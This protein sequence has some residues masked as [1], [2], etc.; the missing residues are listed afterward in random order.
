MAMQEQAWA[1][2]LRRERAGDAS[3]YAWFLKEYSAVLRRVVRGRLASAGLDPQEAED[4]VQEVLLAIHQRR[5]Q[6]DCNRPLLPWLGAISR[7]KTIDAL[8]RRRSERRMRIDLSDREWAS[9]F[10][11]EGEPAVDSGARVEHMVSTLPRVE[12]SVVRKVGMEGLSPR[13]A[14]EATGMKEGTVRVAFHRGLARLLKLA[15]GGGA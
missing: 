7:Y 3:R 1:D 14:A 15:Q 9:L 12:Q 5:D 6:W 8:R 10:A 13:Q 4:I 2:A 11:A